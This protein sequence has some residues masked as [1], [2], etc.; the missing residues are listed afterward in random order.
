MDCVDTKPV[1]VNVSH[2]GVYMYSI[3]HFWRK[4]ASTE[5]NS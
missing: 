3:Q 4:A 2:I 1:N 5:L